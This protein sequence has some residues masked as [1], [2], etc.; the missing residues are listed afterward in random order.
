MIVACVHLDGFAVLWCCAM[1]RV[2]ARRV[3]ATDPDH[4]AAAGGSQS[5]V[6]FTGRDTTGTLQLYHDGHAMIVDTLG[7]GSV[8]SWASDERQRHRY[9]SR[10]VRRIRFL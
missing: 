5:R 3:F 6:G 10:C 8:G 9:R 7:A 1:C 2:V 4:A